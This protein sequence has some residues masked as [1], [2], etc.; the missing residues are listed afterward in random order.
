MFC[1]AGCSEFLAPPQGVT[2]QVLQS[3]TVVV[4]IICFALGYEFSVPQCPAQ[5]VARAQAAHGG[6]S[7]TQ[8]ALMRGL[9]P[10]VSFA[11]LW[12]QPRAL[13]TCSV[14]HLVLVS[15]GQLLVQFPWEFM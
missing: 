10:S 7:G 4:P 2:A 3:C 8:D 1:S 14:S 12:A 15:C 6:A 13:S 11:W 5:P 9:S